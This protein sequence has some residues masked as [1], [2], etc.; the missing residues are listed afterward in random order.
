[1]FRPRSRNHTK[2]FA[3]CAMA[4]LMGL[5]ILS[6][7]SSSASR[8]ESTA[9]HA[10]DGSRH[11]SK[12]R[13]AFLTQDNQQAPELV[14]P[15]MYGGNGGHGNSDSINDGSLV[16]VDQGTAA[17]TLVGH[18]AGVFRL[19]GI[20]FDTTDLLYASTLG[21]G[22]FP[23]PPPPLTSTL[24]RLN[25]DTGALLLTIG[26]ITDGPAGPAISIADL[27]IQPGTGTLFGIRAPVDD[28]GGQG[29]LY[30]IDKATA[31]ATLVGDIHAFFESIA[32]APNGTLYA[33]AAD[34]MMGNEIN[35]RL[36]TINPANGAVLT[37]VATP[38]FYGALGVRRA[39]GV[40]FAGTGDEHNIYRLNATTGAET[41]VGDTG[42]NFVGDLDFRPNQPLLQGLY[43]QTNLVSDIPGFA[44]I[45]DPLLV[46]PWGISMS[47]TS[48]FWTANN[49]TSTATLYGGDVNGSPF[50]KNALNV[51][52][53]GGLPTGA[54]FNG[55][56]DFTFTAGGSTGPARFI[57]ASLTGN[58]AAWKG[59]TS[60]T[61]V[62]T[63]AGH[64]YTGLA[65]GNNGTA[66]FLYGADF[67]NKKIDVYD[68]NF[69][70]AT[71]AGNF[72]D[73]TIPS[74]FAPFNIQNLAGKLYVQYAKVDPATG[75]DLPGPG[76]GY[77]SV[78]DT[79]GIFLGRLVSNGPLNS[80]WG[81]A[82]APASFGTFGGTLLVGNFGDGTI[83]SFNQVSGAFLGALADE[84][85]NPIDIEGL[86]ALTF[87]NGVGGGDLGTLYFSAGYDD[88]NHGL[89]GSLKPAAQATTLIQFGS[90]TYS[91]S[92]TA[93]H[94]DI[95][96]TRTNDL[97][98]PSTVN[99]ATFDGTATQGSDYILAAGTINFGVGE[100]SKTFTVFVTDDVNVESSETVRLALSNPT[101]AALGTPDEATLTIT[102]NDSPSISPT[103]K[104]FVATLNAAQEVP[105]NLTTGRG[106]GLVV[107]DPGGATAKVSLAFAGLSSPANAAHIHGPAAPGTNAPILFPLTVPAA[108]SG[109]VNNVA[110]T[111]TP[112]QLQQLK[113]GL[114]YFNVHTTNNP[115]GEIRGQIFFNPIDESS[116]FVTE[117]YFDFLNRAPDAGGLTF[118]TNEI[119]KCLVDTRCVS[120]RRV[121]VS[122]AFFF[123]QEFQQTGS[124]VYRVRR[125]TLGTQ[126]S[127]GQYIID[128]S[129]LGAGTSADK[130]A[131]TEA[132]TERPEFLAKYPTTQNGSDFIDA[133][134]LTIK[135]AS[136][137][138][139]AVRRP[140]L[141]NEYLLGSSQTQSRARV[142]RK[143]I[144]YPEY[145][146]AEFNPSFVLA[147]YFGYL[148]RDPDPGG[149]AFWLNVLNNNVPGN[150]RT[151]VCAFLTSA[152]YQQRFGPTTT[153]NDKEC[154]DIGP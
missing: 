138:D 45:Q 124:F 38:R 29:K 41:L 74:D 121:G 82:I 126:P 119:D 67:A 60:A 50:T 26:P 131:F 55:S 98:I 19:T 101:G 99:Y 35:P 105:A 14:F 95:T 139:L 9:R 27:A 133:L 137:V 153:R 21:A 53:P 16:I 15:V 31:V 147:E 5:V 89:F 130:T 91:V 120:D 46:N 142:I 30:T 103:Q 117:H 47:A 77:V 145:V 150:F 17:I 56:N 36:I 37:S 149:Y 43:K 58:I 10:S 33:T 154:A 104:T 113:D 107:L 71:L 128:K 93:G 109:S 152:E 7:F 143:A 68:K 123:E 42:Q 79:S 85:G 54:V 63:Q 84:T 32:F 118:W 23:P 94:V 3:V 49:V 76:N 83:N 87:G 88:E 51:A 57:F 11:T 6:Q 25:P 110:I 66:N 108:T 135:T 122:A 127:Y 69:A 48:P 4:G 12:A 80:P 72:T 92:E 34:F 28:G 20:A 24:V 78:F 151:M 39:D 2:R 100:S 114:F 134:I 115:G 65:I 140:D 125:A 146:T 132:F 90:A 13:N 75:E 1:M 70:T 44:Q 59:G 116:F 40:I 111:L 141:V 61:I 148:R 81:V 8:S 22:G 136:G 144:E 52:I 97:S 96:V 18:P 106:T 112:T 64:V 102:D 86:W 73:P 129:L 62:A